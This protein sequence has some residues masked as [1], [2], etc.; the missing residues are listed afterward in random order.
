MTEPKPSTSRD[1]DNQAKF[2]SIVINNIP[3]AINETSL[4]PHVA[5]VNDQGQK[6][7][8]SDGTPF[9]EYYTPDKHGD[10][11]DHIV[12]LWRT[13]IDI[14]RSLDNETIEI[15]NT[16]KTYMNNEQ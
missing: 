7:Y 9:T 8:A 11:Q 5:L 4:K 3:Q 6:A 16:I 2:F 10:L 13:P 12:V 1:F 14:Y 15:L